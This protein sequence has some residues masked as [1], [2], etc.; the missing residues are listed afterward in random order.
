MADKVA[1]Q[2]ELR[3]PM[4]YG[5]E[6]EGFYASNEAATEKAHALG[7]PRVQIINKVVYAEDD[8]E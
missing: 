8:D 2:Y 3:T 7:Y 1:D 5:S 4:R 6:H